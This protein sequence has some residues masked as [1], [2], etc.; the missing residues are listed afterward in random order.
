MKLTIF[1]YGDYVDAVGWGHKCSLKGTTK[2][3]FGVPR[4]W[5]WFPK[6]E[7]TVATHFDVF[8]KV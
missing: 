4:L 7:E 3:V 2:M 6:L 8:W 5:E 1:L